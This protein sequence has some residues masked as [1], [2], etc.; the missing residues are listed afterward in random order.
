MF[1]FFLWFSHF[2]K[3]GFPILRLIKFIVK[4]LLLLDSHFF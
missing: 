4:Q 2:K 3:K 1:P